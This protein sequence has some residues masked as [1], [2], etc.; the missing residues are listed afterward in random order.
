[1]HASGHL[2]CVVVTVIL[3]AHPL[4]GE[5]LNERPSTSDRVGA[6]WANAS[7]DLG[8]K[9]G[10]QLVSELEPALKKCAAMESEDCCVLDNSGCE[11]RPVL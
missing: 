7:T 8:K 10:Q 6:S 11:C 1:M 2:L 5:C 4:G 3:L 9:R